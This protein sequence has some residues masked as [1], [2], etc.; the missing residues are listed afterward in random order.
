MRKILSFLTACKLLKVDSKKLPIVKHLPKQHAQAVVAQY[1]LWTIAD[2]I[3]GK[4]KPDCNNYD[5]KKYYAVFYFEKAKSKNGRSKLVFFSVHGWASASIVGSR[6][7]FEKREQAEYFGKKFIRL[8]EKVH[9]M[10]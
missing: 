1:Q 4:W 7:C 3:R 5:Q 6:L 2:A 8:H 10:Q 9:R